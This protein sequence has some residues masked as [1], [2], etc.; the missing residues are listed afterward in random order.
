MRTGLSARKI[1]PDTSVLIDGRVSDLVE[2]G[3]MKGAHVIV[4]EASTAELE[5]LAN[6]GRGIG[7]KGLRELAKLR[8]HAAANRITLEFFG[9]RPTDVEVEAAPGGAIDNLIR[10]AAL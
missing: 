4:A 7:W 3:D 9:T 1:V 2:Q 10:S 5:H 6:A 8:E